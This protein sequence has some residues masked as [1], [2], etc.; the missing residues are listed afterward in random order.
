ML[1]REE[2]RAKDAVGLAELVRSGVVTAQEVLEAAIADQLE[3]AAPW[4]RRRP[5]QAR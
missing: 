3:D 1:S 5:P 2:Y 4:I